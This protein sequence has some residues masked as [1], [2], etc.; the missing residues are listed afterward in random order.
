MLCWIVL[1]LGCATG[2]PTPLVTFDMLPAAEQERVKPLLTGVGSP[3]DRWTQIVKAACK[4]NPYAN[5]AC[6][7]QPTAT[8]C[9]PSNYDCCSSV[10]FAPNDG[11]SCAYPSPC[12][13]TPPP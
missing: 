3:A 10:V 6:C 13:C 2:E 5:C 8:N 9:N 12:N 7:Q 11:S 4:K 1:F